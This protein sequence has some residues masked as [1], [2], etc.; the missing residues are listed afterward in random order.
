MTIHIITVLNSQFGQFTDLKKKKKSLMSL[1]LV[2]VG[3]RTQF[4]SSGSDPCRLPLPDY[5][6]TRPTGASDPQPPV[7]TN[8]A[9]ATTRQHQQ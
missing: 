4:V 6:G 2:R 8:K 5:P 3:A 1:V 7:Q 9:K